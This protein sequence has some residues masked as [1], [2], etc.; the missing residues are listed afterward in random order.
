MLMIN[1]YKKNWWFTWSLRHGDFAQINGPEMTKVHIIPCVSSMMNYYKQSIGVW[2]LSCI[3]SYIMNIT[4]YIY[5]FGGSKS[6][7]MF[8]YMS[9]NYYIID[10]KIF[11]YII[12]YYLFGYQSVPL[13]K[14]LSI[15]GN[16][17]VPC[18]VVQQRTLRAHG[19][20]AL[21]ATLLKRR[22]NPRG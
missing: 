6:S 21:D 11:V 13:S 17:E 20:S 10:Y 7:Y 3:I 5:W 19:H 16:G 1:K 15:E 12:V 4:I 22:R 18:C 8:L 9:Y 2:K 14:K